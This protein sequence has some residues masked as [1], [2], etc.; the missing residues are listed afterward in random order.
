MSNTEVLA[1]FFGDESFPIEWDSEEEKQLF[2]WYDDLHCPQPISPMWFDV[3]GWWYTCAYMY[4]R[5]GLPFG[6][7]WVAKKINGYVYTAVVPRDPEE[8][9]RLAPYFN[10]V[11]PVYAQNFME[12]WNERLL[13]EVLKNFEY[14]DNYPYDEAT[15]PELMILLEDALDIQERHFR[16]HWQLNLAQFA[17]FMNFEAVAKEVTGKEDL[18]VGDI[19][20][21]VDDRNWDSV[22]GLCALRDKVAA[23]PALRRAFERETGREILQALQESPEGRAFLEN[24]VAD[25]QAEFGYRAMYTHEYIVPTWVED[26]TPVIETVKGYLES[27]YDVEAELQKTVERRNKATEALFAMVTDEEA[28]AKLQEALEMAQ[29]MAPLTPNHHFYFDQ[30][31]YARLRLVFLAIGRKLVEE[32]VLEAAD[33]PIFLTYDEL[34]QLTADFDAFD[35]KALVKQRRAEREAAFQIRPREWVGTATHW[36]I[37]EE[38]YSNLW[39]YPEKFERLQEEGE[40]PKDVVRGLAASPGVAE[41]VARY[42]ATPAE[43][44]QVKPGDILVCKMTNPA[45]VVVFTKIKGLVTDTGGVL[46]HPAIVSREFGIPAVVGTMD[47][48][49]RIKSGQR[50]RV[51]GSTG[52]VEILS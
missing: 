46:S 44:D 31:T 36:A 41:G 24:D 37:Y 18:D 6:K 39:G 27:N 8:A 28:R 4:R 7:D 51:N 1:T 21:S 10:M 25:Y 9:G 20:M 14:L 3:G 29:K 30:G 38:P 49:H 47:A 5:F 19:L 45:W 16:L 23:D 35:A 33:D 15:I 42:V 26:A 34:R 13:P 12:W 52:V 32:G 43:F 40:A 22:R 50:V 2:W 48:T 17:A 11:L